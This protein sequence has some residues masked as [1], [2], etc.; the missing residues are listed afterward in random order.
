MILCENEFYR[1]TLLACL[2]IAHV[3]FRKEGIQDRK[4]S[5]LEGYRKRRIQLR[6]DSRLEGYRKVGF[7]TGGMWNRRD[8][9]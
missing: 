9:E 6:R 3:G 5:G 2:S 7:S 4:D 1:K 8:A